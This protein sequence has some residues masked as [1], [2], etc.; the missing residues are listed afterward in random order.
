MK[1][2]LMIA[3]SVSFTACA[4]SAIVPEGP[5]SYMIYREGGSALSQGGA[6]KIDAIREASAYCAKE[7]KRF[8]ITR[9]SVTPAGPMRF[10]AAEVGFMCLKEGDKDLARPKMEPVADTVIEVRK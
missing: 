8:V 5:D 6:L 1:T 7:G 4:S 10:P 3:L 9:T 2:L